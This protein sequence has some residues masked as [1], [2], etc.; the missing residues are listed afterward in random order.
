MTPP[1]YP[2]RPVNGGPLPKAMPKRGEWSYEPKYNGWRTLVHIATGTMF[3][4]Q[5]EPLSIAHEF[6]AALDQLRVTLD[7]EAFKWAD[8][9]ALERRHDIGRG[10]LIV[11]DVVPDATS[12][13]DLAFYTERRRWL[14]VLPV[15][16]FG[17]K[18]PNDTILLPPI[19]APEQWDDLQWVN[20]NIG[21]EFYE[22]MVAKK[23]NSPYPKQL[24]SP[25]TE[26]PFWMKHRWRF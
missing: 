21:C 23:N 1:T 7:A 6:K 2:L 8:C 3:S 4:R 9:E 18:P 26:F 10:T 11:L 5:G 15:H 14:T 25:D 16:D 20:K 17:I 13:C 19:V 24:R 22:G 12:G